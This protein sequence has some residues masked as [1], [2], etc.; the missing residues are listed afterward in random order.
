[1]EELIKAY[2]IHT[3]HYGADKLIQRVE[4][5]ILHDE[6][7]YRV[8]FVDNWSD[9]IEICNSDLLTFLYERTL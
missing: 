3:Q 1:M 2:L 7:H 8:E 5:F 4:P 9:N 6:Q